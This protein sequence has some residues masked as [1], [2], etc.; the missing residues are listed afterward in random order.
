VRYYYAARAGIKG[1]RVDHNCVDDLLIEF[2]AVVTDRIRSRAAQF[3]I[4]PERNR[5]LRRVSPRRTC[6]DCHCGT[7]HLLALFWCCLR[8][9]LSPNTFCH[10]M[11]EYQSIQFHRLIPRFLLLL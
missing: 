6:V 9:E 11:Q 3:A 1:S 5:S 7:K 4:T 2:A 8:Q 10:E